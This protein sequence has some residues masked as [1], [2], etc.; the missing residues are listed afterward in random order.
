[1]KTLGLNAHMEGW[2]EKDRLRKTTLRLNYIKRILPGAIEPKTSVLKIY[3]F[4]WVLRRFQ[5]CTGHITTRV[6]GRAEE[7]ST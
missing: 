5:H 4:I 1:M 3:L 7:T 2:W 6:V